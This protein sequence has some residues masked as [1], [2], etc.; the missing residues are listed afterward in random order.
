MAQDSG[1]AWVRAVIPAGLAVVFLAVLLWVFTS[2]LDE[3]NSRLEVMTAQLEDF[4]QRVRNAE[5]AADQSKRRAEQAEEM[6]RAAAEGR[7]RME[8][9]LGQ[10]EQR[11]RQAESESGEMRQALETTR[12]QLARLEE[13]RAQEIN[14]LQRALQRIA[15]TRRT[16]G[17]LVMN[18][19]DDTVKFDFDRAEIK[20]EYREVLSR[21]A[22]ILLTSSGFRVQIYGHTDD[23]G[24]DAYNQALSERRAAAVREYLVSAG[25]DPAIVSVRGFGKSNPLVAGNTPEIRA[26]NRRVEIGIIDT[27][28]NYEVVADP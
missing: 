27:V 19:D 20:P 8:S 10:V 21:I 17:G 6:S 5:T 28:I 2:R 11:A 22:G 23:V 13:E 14:R 24:T 18:L 26:R 1:S 15:Q 7:D 9:V 16:R 25:I 4:S 3:V 12:E